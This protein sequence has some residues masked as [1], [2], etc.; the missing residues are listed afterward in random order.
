MK[1]HYFRPKKQK[2]GLLYQVFIIVAIIQIALLIGFSGMVITQSIIKEETVMQ[3]PPTQEQ[4]KPAEQEY[5]VKVERTQ[6]NT[7]KLNKRISIVNPQN[8]SAPE[9]NITLPATMNIGGGINT[10]SS[11]DMKGTLNIGA[12][13]VEIFNI[14]SKTEKVLICIDASPYLMTEERG[15]LDT[16]KVI[17]EDI[18]KLINALPPTTLFNLMAFDTTDGIR[19]DFF[20]STL[21]AATPFNKRMAADWINPINASLTQIGPRRN[22]YKLKYP[23]L[24]QPPASEFYNPYR[25]NIYRVF[26]AALE[27]GADTIYMLTTDWLD[28]DYIKMPWTDAQTQKFQR[29]M[30]RYNKEVERQRKAQGWTEDDQLEYERAR[31]TA[32]AAATAKAREWIKKENASRKEKGLSLYAGTTSDAVRENK[33]YEAPAK[34]PPAVKAVR[35]EPKF[36]SYGRN[37][38]FKFYE[39]LFKEV[40]FSKNMKAPTVNM[41]VFRGKNEE[42]TPAQNKVVVRFANSNN[43]GRSRVLRGLKPVSEAG[44]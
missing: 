43:G 16:Y 20:Q 3:A 5:R 8:V 35:P 28:P 17:R 40:Y 41:I 14:K 10:V 24:P 12:T 1:L 32:M 9:V 11:L 39:Q 13:T 19:I 26:Q 34:R 38:I 23:F 30:E 25:T 6:K 2:K 29:D 7:K 27:Q 33:F 31:A 21:V 18:K 15:G 37:G 22:N 42:W 44:N 4:V 36:K